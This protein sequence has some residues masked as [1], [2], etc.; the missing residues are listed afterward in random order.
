[1]NLSRKVPWSS[2]HLC[3]L[4]IGSSVH[5]FAAAA[6]LS[7]HKHIT[8]TPAVQF[9][10]VGLATVTQPS[11]DSQALSLGSSHQEGPTGEVLS[12]ASL[13]EVKISQDMGPTSIAQLAVPASQAL[14]PSLCGVLFTP[15]RHHM[16]SMCL[17]SVW[18]LPH[19][20]HPISPSLLRNKLQDSISRFLVQFCP[21]NLD[22]CNSVHNVRQTNTC[23]FVSKESV[24]TCPFTCLI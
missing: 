4:E 8:D 16:F 14:F 10:R 1:M 7:T 13:R 6:A 9:G 21:W 20:G 19:H 12:C 24:I 22:K 18:V 17:A 3:C 5:R 15:S 11:R 23:V 2:S